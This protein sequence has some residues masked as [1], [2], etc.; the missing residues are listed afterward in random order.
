MAQWSGNL[1]NR[2]EEGRQFCPVIEVGTG[3]T[4]YHYSD[5]TA[6]EVTAVRDQ[7]HVTV[8]RLDHKHVGD[9]CMDNNWE[10]VSNPDN[11]LCDMVKVGEVWYWTNTITAADLAQYE[12]QEGEDAQ[13]MLLRLAVGGWD[14]DRIRTKGK[15]TKRWKANV[16]FGVA[17][18]YYDY[19]F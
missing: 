2:L 14:I 13:Y 10:L 16:S 9:G 1:T 8:R 19:E 6:Y 18:Y 12:A 3:M 4:E 15:Q 11:P 5:R 7:K 17:D